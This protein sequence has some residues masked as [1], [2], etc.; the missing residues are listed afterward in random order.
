[1]GAKKVGKGRRALALSLFCMLTGPFA[2]YYS[3]MSH[4]AILLWLGLAETAFGMAL[5]VLRA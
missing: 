4:V 2:M 1:M 5:A 3:I